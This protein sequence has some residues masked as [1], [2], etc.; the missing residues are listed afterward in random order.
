MMQWTRLNGNILVAATMMTTNNSTGRMTIPASTHSFA[1]LFMITVSLALLA[2]ESRIWKKTCKTDQNLPAKNTCSSD[3]VSRKLINQKRILLQMALQLSFLPRY[4]LLLFQQ[5][6]WGLKCLTVL[7]IWRSFVHH[8]WIIYSA[9]L[10]VGSN[11]F[12]AATIFFLILFL[13]LFINLK[14]N[15]V[16]YLFIEFIIFLNM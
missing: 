5:H 14:M 2:S 16:L 4:L 8:C 13:F 1:G 6:V 7:I 11:I 10:R 12:M 15:F 3:C 9:Y